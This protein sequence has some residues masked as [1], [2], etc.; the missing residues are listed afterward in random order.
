MSQQQYMPQEHQELTED[1]YYDMK[2]EEYNILISYVEEFL[3]DNSNNLKVFCGI[4]GEDIKENVNNSIE[5]LTNAINNTGLSGGTNIPVSNLQE[6]MKQFKNLYIKFTS[7]NLT[8]D[9]HM[10]N[11]LQ[12][13][14]RDTSFLNNVKRMSQNPSIVEI[15]R[16]KI[17]NVANNIA[18]S[19]DKLSFQQKINGLQSL[20]SSFLKM[21]WKKFTQLFKIPD[22]QF[23]EIRDTSKFFKKLID[24]VNNKLKLGDNV[25]IRND[26]LKNKIDALEK[27]LK[28]VSLMI[29]SY[30]N[31]TAPSSPDFK[32]LETIIGYLNT[33][34]DDITKVNNFVSNS[35]SDNNYP[36][37]SVYS[38][39]NEIYKK[40]KLISITTAHLKYLQ[41]N[42]R[43]DKQEISEVEKRLYD[44]TSE[45]DK[46]KLNQNSSSSN[47]TIIDIYNNAIQELVAIFEVIPNYMGVSLPDMFSESNVLKDT[48]QKLNN[49]SVNIRPTNEIVSPI[50]KI[51]NTVGNKLM[52]SLPKFVFNNNLNLVPNIPFED[53]FSIFMFANFQIIDIISGGILP[54]INMSI[55]LLH[56]IVVYTKQNHNQ[57]INKVQL[58]HL[59]QIKQQQ[60]ARLGKTTTV[61][62]SIKLP[63]INIKGGNLPSIYGKQ[64]FPNSRE[65]QNPREKLGLKVDNVTQIIQIITHSLNKR[66]LD[67]ELFQQT[68]KNAKFLLDHD[69]GIQLKNLTE[70]INT[71]NRNNNIYIDDIDINTE[72]NKINTEIED[73]NLTEFEEFVVEYIVDD[74]KNPQSGGKKI[75]SLT[76]KQVKDIVSFLDGKTREEL[77]MYSK[78]KKLHINSKMKKEELINSILSNHKKTRKIKNM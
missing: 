8:L 7:Y 18:N 26:T 44:L 15:A 43:Y 38:K 13:V 49:T 32:F 56:Y 76:S 28:F 5:E 60:N 3:T 75:K 16:E 36:S 72:K 59:K 6:Q 9:Y 45:L 19:Y 68:I 69:D 24:F 14:S 20:F 64:V 54:L 33:I 70:N 57:N 74:N 34:K 62:T 55:L 27:L 21:L 10:S 65:E 58:S 46:L 37:S 48:L 2:I 17:G 25:N 73:K 47:P 35:V 30:K 53:I 71:N 67:G 4:S 78:S 11:L 22:I 77:Y 42:E 39:H 1:Y 29:I 41:S 51:I 12:K 50:K 52:E 66:S 40:Q 23:N 63:P 31:H 61:S